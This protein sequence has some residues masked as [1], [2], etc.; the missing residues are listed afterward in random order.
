MDTIN[1]SGFSPGFYVDISAYAELKERML[2]CHLSQI[3][4]GTDGDFS[5]LL[6]MMRVQCRARGLQ[7]GVAAAEA[8]RAHH[9]FKRARAW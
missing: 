8:F 3:A 2:G 7:A 6:E 5:P 4:R 9:A 1:M